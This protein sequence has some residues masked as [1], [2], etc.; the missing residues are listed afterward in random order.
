MQRYPVRAQRQRAL[1]MA[2]VRR[3]KISW[4]NDDR[5]AML[6]ELVVQAMDVLSPFLEL[7]EDKEDEEPGAE[8]GDTD[9]KDET[10]CKDSEAGGDEVHRDD[11]SEHK[12]DSKQPTK[13]STH[14]HALLCLDALGMLKSILEFKSLHKWSFLF[15]KNPKGYRDA[16]VAARLVNS[17]CEIVLCFVVTQRS[18]VTQEIVDPLEKLLAAFRETYIN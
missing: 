17:L 10:K 13:E 8:A 15:K 6:E 7:F 18:V 14:C 3:Q 11:E 5:R 12:N 16:P 4:R 1:K 2:T 9:N